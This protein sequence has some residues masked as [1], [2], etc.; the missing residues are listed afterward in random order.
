MKFDKGRMM[1]L[2]NCSMILSGIE[3]LDDSE[4]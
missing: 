2:Q 1:E 3:L 4:N